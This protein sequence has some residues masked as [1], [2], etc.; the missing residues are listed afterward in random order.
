MANLGY[1][2]SQT[3]QLLGELYD[4]R[5]ISDPTLSTQ[6]SAFRSR[7]DATSVVATLT[8]LGMVA[9]RCDLELPALTG[10]ASNNR[11]Y[12]DD[13]PECLGAIVPRPMSV[14][15]LR[16]PVCEL[17]NGAVM[18]YWL[19]VRGFLSCAIVQSSSPFAL[20]RIS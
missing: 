16:N 15:S 20:E 14:I 7:D 10:K 5:H 19:I 3:L 13:R 4:C 12:R 18:L 17:G 11:F 6:A 9:I 8:T 2:Q 1:P